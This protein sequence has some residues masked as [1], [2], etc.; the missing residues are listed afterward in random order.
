MSNA[1]KINDQKGL[2]FITMTVVDWIDLFTRD[3]NRKI[4]IDSLDY[5]RKN[6]GLNIWA[7]VIMTNHLH[8]IVNTKNSLSDILRDFKRYTTKNLLASINQNSESRRSWILKAFEEAGKSE[9]RED[10]NHKIWLSDNHPIELLTNEFI[11][12]K[13]GYIHVN[14]VR[15]GL[16][17]D[18]SAW[19]YS[20]QRN[21]MRLPSVL[22]IDLLD[23]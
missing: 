12:Q 6:K 15:S 16:V 22:E 17:D 3:T 5:C 21:Y 13:M 23:Y 19:V 2:Y 8:L 20:S 1:F 10:I 9:M 7:Y 18:P 11:L 4:I 14:P